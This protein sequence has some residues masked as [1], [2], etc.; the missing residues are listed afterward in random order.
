MAAEMC[1]E[2]LSK[3]NTCAGCDRRY[4]ELYDAISTIS[5][6][7]ILA[8]SK[9]FEFPHY[10]GVEMSIH[11]ACP[12]RTEERVNSAIKKLLERMNIK[13]MEPGNTG[14]KASVL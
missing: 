12:T 2:I 6:W 8:E 1:E 11:D 14:S 9:T 4:R 10:N 3:I 5:L 13:I 7:E